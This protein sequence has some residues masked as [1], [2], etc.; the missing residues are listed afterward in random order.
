MK[1]LSLLTAVALC[2]LSASAAAQAPVADA[3]RALQQR[4]AK[5]LIAGFEEIPADKYGFK[6]TAAQMSVGDITV[7]L[8]EGND[9]LC[10]KIGGTPAPKRPEL[11]GTAAKDKLIARLKE[12]FQFCETALAKLNDS[13]LGGMVPFFGNRQVSRARAIRARPR[14]SISPPT[15]A[16]TTA[17]SRST[18][19]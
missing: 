9:Y 1:A 2:S 16:T 6:P 5:N 17:S 3:L 13:D 19:A 14:R 18:C 10:S 12:S 7:H 11:A 15:G 8:A 4:S